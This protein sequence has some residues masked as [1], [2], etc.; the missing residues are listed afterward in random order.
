MS[1][2]SYHL[3]H[4]GRQKRKLELRL[5][6]PVF[7]SL[8]DAITSCM[9]AIWSSMTS[10]FTRPL[11]LQVPSVLS[12]VRS[13]HITSA[14]TLMQQLSTNTTARTE[15]EPYLLVRLLLCPTQ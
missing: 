10:R 6:A 7:V 11:L 5:N 1:V 2:A 4:I 9:A 15:L 14:T 3:H 8:Q 13:I 12:L